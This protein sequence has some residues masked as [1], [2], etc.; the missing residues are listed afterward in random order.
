MSALVLVAQIAAAAAN[1]MAGRRGGLV[2]NTAAA[3]FAFAAGIQLA[4]LLSGV[5]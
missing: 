2:W 1:L 5:R 4:G 3:F